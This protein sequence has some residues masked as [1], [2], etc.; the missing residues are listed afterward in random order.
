M[1]HHS[2]TAAM[3]ADIE[4]DRAALAS[5]LNALQDRVSIDHLAQ[6]A[7]GMIRTNA[8]A[9]TRSIDHAVRANPL[10]L[11]LAG[12]GLT[13]LIFGNKRPAA[14]P[15]KPVAIS[16]WED[17]GGSLV[18]PAHTPT[19]SGEAE[20][21]RIVG[22]LSDKASAKLRKIESES[23][24]FASDLGSG[25]VGG[26]G[27]ARDYTVEKAAVV[28]ELVQGMKRGLVHG[29]D[30]LSDQARD[31][32]VTARERA[33]AARIR[34]ERAL[35]HGM[36]EPGRLIEDYPLIASAVALAV[37]AAL[38][39]SPPRTETEDRVFGGESDRLMDE[40]GQLLR[41]ERGRL[42]R[43]AEGVADEL[44]D[45]P[46]KRLPPCRRRP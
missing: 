38:A 10:A 11:A 4:R 2:D 28:A 13:W 45:P 21:W 31:R 22:S 29:L 12:A 36:R 30:G 7:L 14:Q 34:A 40:A 5:T 16:R 8:T 20:W 32:I 39:A 23:R 26:L 42:V 6:E 43:A 3:E 27:Q 41:Q 1:T 46:R 18:L 17:E 35:N 24:A 44:K 25:A 9:Y 15:V 37:G 33:Y 19:A